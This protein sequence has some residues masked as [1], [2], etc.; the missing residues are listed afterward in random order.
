MKYD[1]ITKLSYFDIN[2]LIGNAIKHL[3]KLGYRPKT[4]K[5]YQY[6]WNVFRR[7]AKDNMV[8]DIGF[9]DLVQRFLKSKGISSNQSETKLNFY[10][11][12]TMNIMRILT[13]FFCMAVYNAV[14]KVQR[15]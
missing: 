1:T 15:K 9:T 8:D 13:D 2:D 3:D 4:Q 5:Y 6:T 14:V 12:Q 7:F 10:Q 11:K